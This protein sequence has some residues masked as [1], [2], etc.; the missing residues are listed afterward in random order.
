MAT[1]EWHFPFIQYTVGYSVSKWI[2]GR[3]TRLDILTTISI[4]TITSTLHQEWAQTRWRPNKATA[5]CEVINRNETDN[6]RRCCRCR[7][8]SAC[9]LEAGNRRRKKG[10]GKKAV[11]E[12][13]RMHCTLAFVLPKTHLVLAR[14]R[15][16]EG[17]FPATPP[18]KLKTRFTE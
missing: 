10:V 6:C 9:Q 5:N 18:K 7:E 13:K 11:L 2:N 4:T 15:T 3:K 8:L 1:T 14:T 17:W 12:W 16:K